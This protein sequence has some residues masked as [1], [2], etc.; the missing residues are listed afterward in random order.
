MA[1]KQ[2]K[3]LNR[4]FWERGKGKRSLGKQTGDQYVQNSVRSA[5]N[6]V[7]ESRKN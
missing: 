6:T 1:E 3:T 5:R 7:E 2:K 4:G